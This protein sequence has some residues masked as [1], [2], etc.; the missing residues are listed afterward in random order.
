MEEFNRFLIILARPSE[1]GNVGAA[2][3]AMKTMGFSRLAIVAPERELDPRDVGMMAVHAMD[4]YEGATFHDTLLDA[5]SGSSLVVAMTRRRGRKR[6][7]FSVP[8]QEFSADAWKRPGPIALVFGNERT[9]L[10]GDEVD[11][12]HMA[13]HIPASDEFP[14]L[15]LAQAVMVACWE[16]ART[17]P[18]LLAGGPVPALAADLELAS[19][20]A[21]ACLERMGFFRLAGREDMRRFL[22]DLLGRAALCPSE[23]SVFSSIFRKCEGLW[24]AAGGAP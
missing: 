16:L 20:D 1:S 8:I 22:R 9:G 14:S 11:L 4:V 18:G 23:V 17:R 12:C 7:A 21:V 6:K 2:C 24:K 15:N 19:E 3:R 5:V 13:A 10:S